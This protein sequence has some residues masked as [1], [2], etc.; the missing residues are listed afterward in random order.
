MQLRLTLPE[1]GVKIVEFQLIQNAEHA[2]ATTRARVEAV[3]T[4]ASAEVSARAR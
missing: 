2:P 4:S 1:S 3:G